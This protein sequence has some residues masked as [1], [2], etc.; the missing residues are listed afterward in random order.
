MFFLMNSG[1]VGTHG[2]SLFTTAGSDFGQ[3]R[4]ALKMSTI[5]FVH[6]DFLRLGTPLVGVANPPTW[7]LEHVTSSVRHAVR[8]V[9]ETAITQ[10]ADFLFIAG[11]VC[12]SSEDLESVVH[13]LSEQFAPLRRNGIQV[14][15]VA[16]D[17]RTAATLRSACDI[18]ISRTDSLHATKSAHAGVQLSTQIQHTDHTHALLVST[19]SHAVVSHA[20]SGRLNYRAIPATRSSADCSRAANQRSLCLSAGAVQTISSQETW[21]CGCIVVDADLTAQ[22][23][24]SSFFVT[25]P[26][27]F[28]TET[29][30]L[31]ELT[32]ADRLVSEITQASKSLQ[33][34]SGQTVIVDWFI[35]TTL[36]SDAQELSDL[37][38][39]HLLGRLRNQLEAGHQGVW[40]R[41][42]MFREN[43]ALQL[44]AANGAAVEEYFDVLTGSVTTHE[45][46]SFGRSVNVL[47]GG[48]GV[49][50][51]LVVGLQLLRDAA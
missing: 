35:N 13:W 18:V 31:K 5:R 9:I 49:A 38:E 11:S 10:Q 48:R 28:A 29:L 46:D 36:N 23:L 27:R 33:R 1:P 50:D 4:E 25:N 26:V 43:A 32:S 3:C 6:T 51:E 20:D 7:L 17:Q 12:D 30:E 8:N 19:G 24:A 16:D 39:H 15:A 14:V 42:V 44:V 22:S 37:Q 34:N 40:P 45:T 41:R 21:N 47:R 2:L